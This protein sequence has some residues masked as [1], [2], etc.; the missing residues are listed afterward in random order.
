MLSLFSNTSPILGATLCSVI[1]SPEDNF[2][3]LDFIVHFSFYLFLSS[4]KDYEAIYMI[5]KIEKMF[6]LEKF[7][8]IDLT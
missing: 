7:S 1:V 8:I 3:A 5:W 6:D 4:H 2:S